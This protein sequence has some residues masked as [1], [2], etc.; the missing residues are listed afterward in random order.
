MKQQGFPSMLMFGREMGLSFDAM[1]DKPPLEEPFGYPPFVKKVY[2][3]PYISTYRIQCEEVAPF[4]ARGKMRLIVHFNRLKP[5]L[6]RPVELHPSL[7]DVEEYRNLFTDLRVGEHA[8]MKSPLTTDPA[9]M[10]RSA[11]ISNETDPRVR[12][13][14]RSRHS[15][16]NGKLP[17]R[18]RL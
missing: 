11:D 12:R 17:L 14:A 2:F 3:Y 13:S 1:R 8:V 16:P 15:L 4:R 6:T 9:P 5:Y 18:K 10:G 7:Y